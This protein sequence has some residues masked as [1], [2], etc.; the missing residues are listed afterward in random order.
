M[1]SLS[2]VVVV[3][4]L[5]PNKIAKEE[6]CQGTNEQPIEVHILQRLEMECHTLHPTLQ[7]KPS[8]SQG[9]RKSVK[10]QMSSPLKCISFR[11]A[12]DGMPHFA[13]NFTGQASNSQ[14]KWED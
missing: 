14:G 7:D 6:K 8:N 10:E 5:K 1:E 3:P 4:K 12:G 9:K 11:D 13:S 2:L